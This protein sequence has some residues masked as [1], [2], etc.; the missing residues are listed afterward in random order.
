MPVEV[1]I[2]EDEDA[3]D[4]SSSDSSSD[5][6]EKEK[7]EQK[8]KTTGKALGEPAGSSEK[9]DEPQK[10][11]MPAAETSGKPS[12]SN[13]VTENKAPGDTGNT[14][15]GSALSCSIKH[16]AIRLMS[17]RDQ[18]S[19]CLAKV[20]QKWRKRRRRFWQNWKSSLFASLMEICVF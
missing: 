3:W 11:E 18:H 5:S 17:K 16:V 9:L 2:A 4:S 8:D 19:T 7:D 6:D 10:N 12:G 15:D 14:G 13:D 20:F 1:E